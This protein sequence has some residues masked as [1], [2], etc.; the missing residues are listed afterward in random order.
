MSFFEQAKY[1]VARD[2]NLKNIAG[3]LITIAHTDNKV[4]NF[5]TINNV[6][7]P[8]DVATHIANMIVLMKSFGEEQLDTKMIQLAV[9]NWH[10]D[11]FKE[12]EGLMCQ[13]FELSQILLDKANPMILEIMGYLVE[14][15]KSCGKLEEAKTLATEIQNR[16]KR[17]KEDH[18]PIQ[19]N[20]KE[21]KK[22][23]E[24]S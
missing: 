6:L 21:T 10:R 14:I 22:V 24:K 3:D 4:V 18:Q 15:Y 12:A 2:S 23:E 9:T 7:V 5:N 11:R 17:T 20:Q 16:K 19:N 1:V 8:N 13:A